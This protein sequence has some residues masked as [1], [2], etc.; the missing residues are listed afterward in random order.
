MASEMANIIHLWPI[1]KPQWHQAVPSVLAWSQYSLNHH[2][3][4]M[5][6]QLMA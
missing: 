6:I 1:G 3:V 4:T 5:S 2:A